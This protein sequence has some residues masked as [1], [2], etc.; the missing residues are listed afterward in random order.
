MKVSYFGFGL[1]GLVLLLI[2]LT[3]TPNYIYI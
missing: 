3:M 1:T 2:K